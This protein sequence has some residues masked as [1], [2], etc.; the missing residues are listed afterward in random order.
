MA[1]PA[2]PLKHL[3][4]EKIKAKIGSIVEEAPY[5]VGRGGLACT[6]KESYAGARASLI[7]V[8]LQTYPVLMMRKE[9]PE[10][11]RISSIIEVDPRVKLS[12]SNAVFIRPDL[13]GNPNHIC[14]AIPCRSEA[15]LK[16]LLPDEILKRMFRALALWRYPEHGTV[17]LCISISMRG[18]C[19][20][21]H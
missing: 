16:L 8:A 13:D 9:F 21:H 11:F 1:S 18:R 17:C 6:D 14:V 15:S 10:D 5:V 7:L 4:W 3:N 2:G 20:P 12:H 19:A